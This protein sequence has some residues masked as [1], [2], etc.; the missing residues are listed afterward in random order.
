[1]CH[2]LALMNDW[3]MEVVDFETEFLYGIL[4]EEI[5]MKIPEGLDLYMRCDFSTEKCLVLD[6]AINGLVQE[7]SETIS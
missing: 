2:G 7:A 4:D 3:E 1:M 6:K 5:F